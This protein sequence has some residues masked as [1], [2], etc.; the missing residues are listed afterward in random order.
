VK[1]EIPTIETPRLV[2]RPFTEDDIDRF[3]GILC[4]SGM[5]RYFPKTDPPPWDQ[6]ED[7][8]LKIIKHWEERGYGLW[9]VEPKSQRVLIGRCGLQYLPDTDEIEA[10]GLLS[11]AYWSKGYATEG[12]KAGLRY[13]FLELK[14]DFVVGIVHPEN[15]AS[16]RVL[17]KI[18]MRLSGRKPYFGMDCYRYVIERDEYL[19]ASDSDDSGG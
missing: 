3:H 5:L 9:V 14:L 13:G 17:E 1:T 2:L 4:E 15:M 10:D 11:T 6:V 16:R 12:A 18:G 19:K 8:V 7:M